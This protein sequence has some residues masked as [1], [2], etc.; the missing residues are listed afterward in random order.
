MRVKQVSSALKVLASSMSMTK[1]EARR[2]EDK[3]GI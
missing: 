2:T 1:G 3:G